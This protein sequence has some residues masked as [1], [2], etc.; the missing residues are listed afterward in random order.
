MAKGNEDSGTCERGASNVAE[1]TGAPAQPALDE[2]EQLLLKSSSIRFNA[3]SRAI[4]DSSD[5][6]RRQ[7]DRH[8]VFSDEDA[9]IERKIVKIAQTTDN[10]VLREKAV[11]AITLANYR[12]LQAKSRDYA[13]KYEH[14]GVTREK[15]ESSGMVGLLA[16][17]D[18][19]DC[20]RGIKFLG[21]AQDRIVMYMRREVVAHTRDFYGVSYGDDIFYDLQKVK[22]ARSKLQ[23]SRGDMYDPSAEEIAQAINDRA[24]DVGGRETKDPMTA[25]RVE[26]LLERDVRAKSN[27]E[28]IYS[29]E[30]EITEFGSTLQSDEVSIAEQATSSAVGGIVVEAFDALDENVKRVME[31][32]LDYE[33]AGWSRK[34]VNE[35]CDLLGMKRSQ[36]VRLRAKGMDGLVDGLRE[37][38]IESA[39][40]LFG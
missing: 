26:F 13:K 4:A 14:M 2:V 24:A 33:P 39:E 7:L 29:D 19:F 40:G 28:S 6:L 8:R 22:F 16:S 25:E 30:G 3:R 17:I 12:F 20:D 34:E 1:M 18:A 36:V 35:I 38:G 32:S 10:P 15:L 31:H 11:E 5:V 27:Q 23:H 9:A 37:H 21:Y